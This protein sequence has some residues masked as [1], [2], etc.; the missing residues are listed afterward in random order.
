MTRI[1]SSLGVLATAAI[2]GAGVPTIA[3]AWPASP[4]TGLAISA[5]SIITITSAALAL[6]IL[7]VLTRAA[8]S[9]LTIPVRVDERPR[10]QR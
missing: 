4:S 2:A 8:S 7:V 6:R 5:A 1:R 9:P 10:R 3:V